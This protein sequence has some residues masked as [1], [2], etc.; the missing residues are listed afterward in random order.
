MRG[1]AEHSAGTADSE[2]S[3]ISSMGEMLARIRQVTEQETVRL[4]DVIAAMGR[5]SHAAL[6]ML[7]AMIVVTPLSGIP[8]LS[9]IGGIMI[10]LISAQMLIGRERVWLPGWI[11]R[12][13]LRRT[14]LLTA[15]TWLDKISAYIDRHTK[16]RLM[17]FLVWPGRVLVQALCMICGMAMPLFELVPFSSTTLACAV[18]LF[19]TAL[20]VRDGLLAAIGIGAVSAAAAL[21]IYLF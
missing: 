4:S 9:S 16:R 3:E 21:F 5:A 10:A 1:E 12:L 7:P 2:P 6:L 20:L 11:L 14:R 17:W 8:G 18:L 15:L 19:A 13:K